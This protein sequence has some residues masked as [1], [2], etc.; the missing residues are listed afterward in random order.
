M[1]F[2]YDIKKQLLEIG[3]EFEQKFVKKAQNAPG[4]PDPAHM[5]AIALKMLDNLQNSLEDVFTKDLKDLRSLVNYCLDKKIEREGRRLVLRFQ[6][7]GFGSEVGAEFAGLDDDVKAEYAPYPSNNPAYMVH[8]AG[9]VRMIQELQSEATATK[10]KIAEVMLGKL[11]D[12]ANR[13]LNLGM[14]KT[15]RTEAAGDADIPTVTPVPEGKDGNKGNQGTGQSN[16]QDSG[17]PAT[18]GEMAKAIK[19]ALSGM[20][21]L[22][23]V[24]DLIIIKRFFETMREWS[25]NPQHQE[26]FNQMLSSEIGAPVD[27]PILIQKK[28][29]I[30]QIGRDGLRYVDDLLRLV[31]KSRIQ[32]QDVAGS[33][34]KNNVDTFA[35]SV[36]KDGNNSASHVAN[37]ANVLSYLVN[38]V[39]ALEEEI[40]QNDSFITEQGQIA[41]TWI[42]YFGRLQSAAQIAARTDQAKLV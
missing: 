34:G 26:R 29:L 16:K 8:K 18:K 30:A 39:Y 3:A 4:T 22:S 6:E 5:N 1:S 17:T 19:S 2:V 40:I 37:V 32:L 11:V 42:Q 33:A 15:P 13:D 38:R 31:A 36:L 10:N 28:Q 25:N 12:E 35:A 14:K 9:M 27:S 24:L 41:Q 20:Y 23:N 21:P 7:S